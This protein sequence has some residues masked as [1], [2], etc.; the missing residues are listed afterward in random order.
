[1]I[2]FTW[3][4]LMTGI[5][6]WKDYDEAECIKAW[7]RLVQ[8]Y[9]ST[10]LMYAVYGGFV[11]GDIDTSSTI[12]GDMDHDTAIPYVDLMK[13]GDEIEICENSINRRSSIPLSLVQNILDNQ[14]NLKAKLSELKNIYTLDDL[15][16][17]KLEVNIGWKER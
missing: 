6:K 14:E 16:N 5:I 7:G 3:N 9:S 13:N 12:L 4:L 17:L 2:D 15:N 1:V 10:D 11:K 8:Q